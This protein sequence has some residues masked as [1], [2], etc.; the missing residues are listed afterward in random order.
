MPS[1]LNKKVLSQNYFS[2]TPLLVILLRLVNKVRCLIKL[3]GK[4]RV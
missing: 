4:G 3:T 2:I 1:G